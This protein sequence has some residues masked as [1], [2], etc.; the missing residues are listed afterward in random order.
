MERKFPMMSLK[1]VSKTSLLNLWRISLLLISVLGTSTATYSQDGSFQL[2]D[3]IRAP[4][5]GT[6]YE[7]RVMAIKN[8]GKYLNV[9]FSDG[10]G[11]T[12]NRTIPAAQATLVKR[13]APMPK[14]DSKE[15]T[16]SKNTNPSKSAG[17]LNASANEGTPGTR[18]EQMFESADQTRQWTRRDG[19]LFVE[20]KLLEQVDGM[21]RFESVDGDIVSIELKDLAL[22]DRIL[23][24]KQ[25]N[26]VSS[27][28]FALGKLP[29]DSEKRVLGNQNAFFA[30]SNYV[31]TNLNP[32]AF[33]IKT[34]V[35]TDNWTYSPDQA[36]PTWSDSTRLDYDIPGDEPERVG[37]KKS[38]DG[39]RGIVLINRQASESSTPK[40]GSYKILAGWNNPSLRGLDLKTGQYLDEFQIQMTDL[41]LGGVD[42]NYRLLTKSGFRFDLWDAKAGKHLGG[43]KL[44][45][46]VMRA[47][48][49]EGG[50]VM[51]LDDQG[52]TYVLQADGLK[53]MYA[54]KLDSRGDFCLSP[55]HK[56]FAT[57]LNDSIVIVEVATG[58]VAASIPGA[59]M[60]RRMAF[61]PSG[62]KLIGSYMAAT[63]FIWDL[64]SGTMLN[65]FTSRTGVT[66][67]AWIDEEYVMCNGAYLLSTSLGMKVWYYKGGGPSVTRDGKC[68]FR[69]ATSKRLDLGLVTIPHQEVID[70]LKEFDS[71]EFRLLKPGMK[72]AI[73]L[74]VPFDQEGKRSVYEHFRKQLEQ[75]E[76][77][78][79]DS[80]SQ[81]L[82]IYSEQG[83][84]QTLGASNVGPLQR[85]STSVNFRPTI[86][87]VTITD[88]NRK[89]RWSFSTVVKPTPFMI[90]DRGETIQQ[91]VREECQPSPFHFKLAFIPRFYVRLPINQSTLGSSYIQKLVPR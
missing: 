23:L 65:S 54:F 52:H 31:A 75:H 83:P 64:K 79:D 78:I 60:I 25:A 24:N 14:K 12:L 42:S 10:R 81:V 17:Q 67:P 72:F 9:T 48:L 55:N 62:E 91:K 3:I 58:K 89:E 1:T 28:E 2:N 41:W 90:L 71:D 86:C 27:L 68:W 44:K 18:T 11:N 30:T 8:D 69:P 15:P 22:I 36:V 85:G 74:N 61:S 29:E 7:G 57:G 59:K 35:P 34:F 84:L 66:A 20:G 47:Y 53:P 82:N 70:K 4:I 19:S 80:A 51:V 5:R 76:C 33:V 45:N 16:P 73:R 32:A 37:I 50:F 21:G 77:V 6:D 87:R 88:S 46:K 63:Q 43:L 13:A 56:Y 40:P 49:L 26:R 39:G 38:H